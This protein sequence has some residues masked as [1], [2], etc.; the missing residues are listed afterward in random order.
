MLIN[1]I[2]NAVDALAD[3]SMPIIKIKAEKNDNKIF[4]EIN[5][6]GEGIHPDKIEEIFTP[7]FTTREKGS[8]IGL[9]IS[10]QIMRFFISLKRI[11]QEP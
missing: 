1:L 5:D 7:F 3:T 4:I 2:N 8:G 6:N 10:K 9:S 11:Q